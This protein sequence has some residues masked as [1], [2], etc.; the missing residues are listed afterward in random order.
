MGI[1]RRITLAISVGTRLFATAVS[2]N[3]EL[4]DWQV[5]HLKDKWSDKKLSKIMTIIQDDI[6][7]Y[8]VN[9]LVVKVP[10]KIRLSDGTAHV[11]KGIETIAEDSCMGLQFT[12]M[13][14]LRLFTRAANKYELVR[15]AE[16]K[17]PD[18]RAVLKGRVINQRLYYLSAVEAVVAL[19]IIN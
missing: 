11:M 14:E 16:S 9:N 4:L 15:Y 2:I 19:E 10:P 3:K 6:S 5:Y 8:G 18:I 12:N 17:Y 1:N 13:E 7:R